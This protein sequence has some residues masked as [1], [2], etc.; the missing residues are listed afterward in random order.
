MTSRFLTV[1]LQ[2][3]DDDDV[4]VDDEEFEEDQEDEDDE[5]EEDGGDEEEVETWQVAACPDSLERSYRLN[6]ES[7]LTSAAE[8]A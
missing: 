2:S 1:R 3:D 6:S 5:D 8:P 7:R 4:D